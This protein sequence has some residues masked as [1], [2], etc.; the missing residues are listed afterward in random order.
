MT[1]CFAGFAGV[2]SGLADGLPEDE[3]TI[4]GLTAEHWD[5][6]AHHIFLLEAL[7]D[8][9]TQRKSSDW[10]RHEKYEL[11]VFKPIE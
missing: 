5:L 3:G 6:V 1:V 11:S 7:S 9:S 2:V 4:A 10:G 8:V